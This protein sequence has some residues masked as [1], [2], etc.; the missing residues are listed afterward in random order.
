MVERGDLKVK[1]LSLLLI[2]LVQRKGDSW[3]ES[4]G[5]HLKSCVCPLTW[6]FT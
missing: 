1:R 6:L 5:R 4:R 2:Q 3:Q